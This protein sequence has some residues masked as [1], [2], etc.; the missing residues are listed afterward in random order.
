VFANNSASNISAMLS[1]NTQD[2]DSESFSTL[3]ENYVESLELS[4]VESLRINNNQSE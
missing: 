1:A 2:V 3:L 4:I